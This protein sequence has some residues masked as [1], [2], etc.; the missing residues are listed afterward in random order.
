MCSSRKNTFFRTASLTPPALAFSPLGD[1][2]FEMLILPAAEAE[3]NAAVDEAE[4]VC[5]LA[6]VDLL[7]EMLIFPAAEDEPGTSFA[8]EGDLCVRLHVSGLS[9]QS[10][11]SSSDSHRSS[12][13]EIPGANRYEYVKAISPWPLIHTFLLSLSFNASQLKHFFSWFGLFAA[14]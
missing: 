12:D 11:T 8:A 4:V 1:V 14:E 6:S 7:F 13:P 5:P 2:I 10:C 9:G 3:P